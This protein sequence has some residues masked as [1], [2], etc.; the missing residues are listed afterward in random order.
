MDYKELFEKYQTLLIENNDLRE[1]LVRLKAQLG[2]EESQVFS[3]HKILYLIPEQ[4]KSSFVLESELEPENELEPKCNVLPPGG[5]NKMS[6]SIDKIRLFM[7]LFRGRDD[8]YAKRWEN[9]KNGNINL[10]SFGSTEESIMRLENSN[11]ANE[12]IKDIDI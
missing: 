11:I 9:R 4:E 5:I 3:P 6:D 10:L 7:S 8:V 12:L 1:E 2:I